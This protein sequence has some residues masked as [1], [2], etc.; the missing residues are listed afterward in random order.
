MQIEIPLPYYLQKHEI[1]KAQITNF[2]QKANA[3]ESIQ[4]TRNPYLMGG[5]SI[6]SNKPLMVIRGTY[7]VY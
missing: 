4:M 5:S 6:Y 7:P 3:A 2:S 1:K